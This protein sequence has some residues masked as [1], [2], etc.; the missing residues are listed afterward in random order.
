[1]TEPWLADACSLVEEFRAGRRSPVEELE[2]TLAAIEASTLNA[3]SYVAGD[4]ARTA[5]RA[6]DVSLPFGGVPVGVKELTSVAGWPETEACVALRDRVATHDKTMVQR[7]RAAGAVLVGLTTASEFGG[8]NLTFTKL[9]GA[10]A[11]PWDGARTPGGSSGGS[12]AAVAGGLVTLATGGDGG[13][14]IRI[15][16]AFTGLPGLKTTYG[17]I[18]KGPEVFIGSLTATSGCLSRSVADIARYLD[19]CNGF[20]SRDPN[21]LP[22]VEGW[23]AGLGS[24]DLRGRR[25]VI[26]PNLGVAHVDAE[27]AARTEHTG[28]TLARMA[29]LELVDV[30]VKLPEL[31]LEWALAG[32]AEIR[33][34]LGELYPG[35]AD[36]LTPQ[37]RF[38]LEMSAQLYN[39]EIRARIESRRTAMNEALAEV[40]DQVDFVIAASNPDVA[41]GV[42]GPMPTHVNDFDAG[43]GNNGALTIP[44]NIY[45]N[46]AISIPAGTVRGLPVGIQVLAPHHREAWLLDLARLIEREAPWPTTAPGAPL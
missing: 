7:L 13:G 36:D 26:S 23:E 20:D 1:M 43:P 10:T 28:A 19:V 4:E 41:F 22:R 17:R 40:F 5:A 38:G 11:N 12:A 2:A 25:A 18:P 37:I 31:G 35:C 32:L 16:A 8:I 33:D 29:G 45:G 9:N 27:V 15:P 30:P 39:V 24:Y 3:F 46:P 44:S 6:A 42:K 14:S 34:D 21:S